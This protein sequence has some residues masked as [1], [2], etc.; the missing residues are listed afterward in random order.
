[1]ARIIIKETAPCNHHGEFIKSIDKV[2]KKLEFTTKESEA[3]QR[4]GGFYVNSEIDF[5]KFHFAEE[6]PEVE[7]AVEHGW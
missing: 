6:Y 2:N 7:Y 3:Y 4:D 5:L 1:M